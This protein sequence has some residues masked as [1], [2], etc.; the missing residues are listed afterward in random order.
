MPAVAGTARN[1]VPE[2]S[3]RSTRS[4]VTIV[5]RNNT[6][7][8]HFHL[9]RHPMRAVWAV[10]PVV[11]QAPA[12]KLVQFSVRESIS[13]DVVVEQTT[14][15]KLVEPSVVWSMVGYAVSDHVR[16]TI[17][18]HV[19]RTIVCCV[20]DDPFGRIR[21]RFGPKRSGRYPEDCDDRGQ[22]D[23][24]SHHSLSFCLLGRR[25]AAREPDSTASC[26]DPSHH[27][28]S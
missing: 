23:D 8:W 17:R 10:S 1:S 19:M 25:D 13:V 21:I 6:T 2:R 4:T 5:S 9:Y 20:I 24:S 27:I 7:K 12:S 16:L 22:E 15:S 3:E 26:Q 14:G 18:D 11:Q 28:D